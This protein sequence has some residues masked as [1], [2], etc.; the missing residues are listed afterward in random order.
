MCWDILDDMGKQVIV[1]E[2]VICIKINPENI[3]KHYE[4]RFALMM[5]NTDVKTLERDFRVNNYSKYLH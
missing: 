5:L 4:L 2:N 1:L 3:R